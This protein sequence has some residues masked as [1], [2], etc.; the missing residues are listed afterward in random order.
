MPGK[1]LTNRNHAAPDHL[2]AAQFPC[3]MGLMYR[4]ILFVYLIY[5]ISM[6]GLLS[7]GELHSI[8]LRAEVER[9]ERAFARTMAERDFEAFKS[10]LSGEAIFFS[11]DVALRGKEA[12]AEK[13]RPFFEAPEAPFSWAPRTVEVLGSGTLALSAGPVYDPAGQCVGSFNS[14]WRREQTGEWKIVFDKG[15]KDCE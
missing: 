5:A 2:A 10:F 11:G 12:V 4:S 7:A 13:W 9:T 3:R 14:I 6:P 15:T 1:F 8:G